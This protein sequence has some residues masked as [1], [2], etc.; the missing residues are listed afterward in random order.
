MNQQDGKE[1]RRGREGERKGGRNGG[2]K[3][4]R[5]AGR[6]KVGKKGDSEG[7]QN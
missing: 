3:E 2:R 4:G 1:G 7:F 5:E 6:G